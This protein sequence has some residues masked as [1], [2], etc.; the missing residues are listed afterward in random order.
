MD[1]D[2]GLLQKAGLA[3][4]IVHLCSRVEG[5]SCSGGTPREGLFF[6]EISLAA[7]GLEPACQR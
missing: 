5:A 3:E 1:R 7:L 2:P 6:V 4:I